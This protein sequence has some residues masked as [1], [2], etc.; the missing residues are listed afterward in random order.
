VVAGVHQVT[1]LIGEIS[2]ASAQQSDDVS[3]LGEAVT[4][5]D[6]MTQQNA[7]LV[8]DMAMAARNLKDQAGTLVETVAVFKLS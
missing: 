2:S 7:Q 4:L 3:Q 6:Q 1:G 5:M 8:D